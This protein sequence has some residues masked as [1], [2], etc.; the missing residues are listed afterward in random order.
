M[1]SYSNEYVSVITGTIKMDC[2]VNGRKHSMVLTQGGFAKLDAKTFHALTFLADNTQVEIHFE[3]KYNIIY[4][5][6]SED[7]RLSSK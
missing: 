3:G 7:P 2:W 6:P 4:A 5:N 1:H